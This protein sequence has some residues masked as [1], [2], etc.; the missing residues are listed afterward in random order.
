MT[1]DDIAEA[2]DVSRMTV[3]NH[4]SRKEDM[5]FDLD[6]EGRGDLLSAL[7]KRSKGVSPIE[8]VRLF[9]H[10]AVT[11]KRPYVQFSAEGTDKFLKAI[12]ASDALRARAS[13]IRDELTDLLTVALADA[14]GHSL[15]NPS[16]SLAASLLVSTWVVA[17]LEAHRVFSKS[18]NVKKS[19]VAF[20]GIVDQGV[21]GAKAALKSTPYA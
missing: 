11:E 21:V 19:N 18:H 5:F 14:A 12:Q 3:F 10:W 7:H 1:V 13:A 6:D 2:A 8:S 9:A 17:T 16:A 20:L 4:F 15:P